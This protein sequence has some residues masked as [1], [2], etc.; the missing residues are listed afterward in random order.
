MEI[1]TIMNI[2]MRMYFLTFF[3]FLSGYV[4]Q[5]IKNQYKKLEKT[6][7]YDIVTY[8]P[9]RK[10]LVSDLEKILKEKKDLALT[11]VNIDNIM[12]IFNVVG[13]SKSD[14]VLK[15]IAAYLSK[16]K[17]DEKI[18]IYN[19]YSLRFEFLMKNY[20]ESEINKWLKS[21]KDYVDNIP[22]SIE[23]NEVYLKVYLGTAFLQ[24]S[25]SAESIIEKAY[26]TLGYAYHN[27]MD[28]HIY[29]AKLEESLL[30]TY[31]VSNAKRGIENNE[32]YLEYQPKLNIRKNAIEEVEALIR[33]KHPDLGIIPP[34][35]FI[36][37]LEKTNVMN[38]LTFWVIKN[39][40]ADIVELEK[41][42]IKLNVSVNICPK[43]LENENFL[44]TLTKFMNENKVHPN[45]MNLEITETDLIRDKNKVNRIL[46]LLRI[47]EF[48]ISIDDFGIGYS[49]LS[50]LN[51]F[52]VNYI[53][54]DRSLIKNILGDKKKY[55]LLKNTVQMAHDLNMKVV[56]EG[57]ED[58]DTFMKLAKLGC[59]EIQGYY[60]SK[61]LGKDDL[62]E[63]LKKLPN[64]LFNC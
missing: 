50:Y 45:R 62:E 37:K 11:A 52:P 23:G 17:F 14:L 46:T 64:R 5:G 25:D 6:A 59:E 2:T 49:S 44:K 12:E 7:N 58:K 4:F 15:K 3:G 33:W 9:N 28:Y 19:S 42:G 54:I 24:E 34:N 48:K 27:S 35:E 32:F 29:N 16:I 38:S 43:D 26:K 61:A 36:P 55:E 30:T 8:L 41:K 10:L 13:L 22:L 57:V 18:K 53:K 39:A 21:F 20:N 63:F 51:N 40:L 47:K 1:Q 56:V 31:L 60:V